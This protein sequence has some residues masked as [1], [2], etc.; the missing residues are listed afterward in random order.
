MAKKKQPDFQP[1]KLRVGKHLPK[2]RNVT[3][4]SFKSKKIV[5]KDQ[6][7]KT[8]INTAS[9]TDLIRLT[10]HNNVATKTDA[11]KR[12]VKYIEMHDSL[13]PTYFT[14]ILN[15]IGKLFL[16]FN[17][18][19]REEALNIIKTSADLLTGVQM[20]S[21][22]T[23]LISHMN[24]M[25]THINLS[26]KK[27]SINLLSFLLKSHPNLICH[28]TQLLN[29]LLNMI[30]S[31][32]FQ[33]GDSVNK[34]RKLDDNISTTMT[35][36]E[37][38][39][40]VLKIIAEF[41]E[42]LVGTYA[43]QEEPCE[44]EQK[45]YYDR[46]RPLF[47]Q[48]YA[49]GGLT[50]A[51]ME[52]PSDLLRSKSD[53]TKELNA[54]FS[55][56][57]SVVS[58][59]VTEAIAGLKVSPDNDTLRPDSVEH[60]NTVTQVLCN[61][62]DW[63][64]MDSKIEDENFTPLM[65]SILRQ[66][67]L[68]GFPYRIHENKKG[69]KVKSGQ[70]SCAELNFGIGYLY[71]SFIVGTEFENSVL[72]E[73]LFFILNTLNEKPFQVEKIVSLTLKIIRRFLK[74]FSL[75]YGEKMDV[76]FIDMF[77][78]VFTHLCN[79]AERLKDETMT[80]VIHSFFIEVSLDYD[81]KFLLDRKILDNWAKHAF[82]EVMQMKADKELLKCV[83]LMCCREYPPF[84]ETLQSSKP[85]E[86][87]G[88]LKLNDDEDYQLTIIN[89]I[90]QMTSLPPDFLQ[91]VADLIL[92][93]QSLSLDIISK[94]IR[95]LYNRFVDERV[96]QE[97]FKEFLR[98]LLNVSFDVVAV[99]KAMDKYTP[100]YFH[101]NKYGDE[102][103]S[104]QKEEYSDELIHLLFYVQ[105][106]GCIFT[107][108]PSQ[109]W[110]RHSRIFEV[111]LECL[112][113][114]QDRG[115]AMEVATD[116]FAELLNSKWTFP[117]HSAIALLKLSTYVY[118]FEDYCIP[119]EK[120]SMFTEDLMCS[121]LFYISIVT[122]KEP[123]ENFKSL[124]VSELQN[125]LGLSNENAYTLSHML[126]NRLFDQGTLDEVTLLHVL[127]IIKFL[128]T[129]N[130]ISSNVL[131]LPDFHELFRA[132]EMYCAEDSEQR[133]VLAQIYELLQVPSA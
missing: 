115:I 6:K 102:E 92:S 129:K 51:K 47:I 59:V 24:C 11:L 23:I 16:D 2:G 9:L 126:I 116:F 44:D 70:L 101:G 112:V 39:D 62:A 107:V 35:S 4:T 77:S 7:L 75:N 128:R 14:E 110:E 22:K 67:L 111:C 61:I 50:P 94:L 65:N 48:L 60:L 1:T 55:N 5:T 45:V 104:D 88:F 122:Q 40:Q 49:G 86:V 106:G 125:A 83:N 130:K 56:V 105:Q 12:I 27:D 117:V 100:D 84:I 78:E 81:Y 52:A 33:R 66:K 29:N 28:S 123:H 46:K 37:W 90:T 74:V 121:S 87:I 3:N 109:Q 120:A 91:T 118:L 32:K 76:R 85:S 13:L 19:V 20:C 97:E 8:P 30:S 25:M 63:H 103:S 38:R 26:I 34:K 41:L 57:V 80:K 131:I 36:V 15:T 64:N 58:D 69:A 17:P 127:R 82:T 10:R 114:P 98:F 31:E 71:C 99:E 79:M 54:F 21:F 124:C 96:S 73:R 42:K 113:I 89:L 95:S 93:D 119:Q 108:V 18:K 68:K 43:K 53:V 132:V 72:N 133:A